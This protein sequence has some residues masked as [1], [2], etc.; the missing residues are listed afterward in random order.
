MCCTCP[1]GALRAALVSTSAT[2][3]ALR[4]TLGAPRATLDSPRVTLGSPRATLG[5]P[6]AALHSTR[7]TLCNVCPTRQQLSPQLIRICQCKSERYTEGD[8]IAWSVD[9]TQTQSQI[10]HLAIKGN[11]T[12]RPPPPPPHNSLFSLVKPQNSAFLHGPDTWVLKMRLTH[13]MGTPDNKHSAHCIRR[14]AVHI[15]D[16]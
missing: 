3:H 1:L 9:N 12:I 15:S 7:A 2:L 16:G 6:R 5:S 8:R 14:W 4:G 11:A 13:V 10:A